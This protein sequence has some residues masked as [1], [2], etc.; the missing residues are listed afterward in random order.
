M[1]PESPQLTLGIVQLL[2]SVRSLG[3]LSLGDGQ[4]GTTDGD[5]RLQ[6]LWTKR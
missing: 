1:D 6:M 5:L 3:T 4:T 2:L